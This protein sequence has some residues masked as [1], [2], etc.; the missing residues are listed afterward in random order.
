MDFGLLQVVVVEG[1]HDVETM[2]TS[3]E[4]KDAKDVINRIPNMCSNRIDGDVY[5]LLSGLATQNNHTRLNAFHH[6]GPNL[7]R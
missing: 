2:V 1:G 7:T 6:D 4:A 5:N 3:D